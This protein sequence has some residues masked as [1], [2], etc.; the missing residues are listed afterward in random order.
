MPKKASPSV[1]RPKKEYATTAIT[2]HVHT[3][4]LRAARAMA[5][6]EGV[7]TGDLITVA[8][9]RYIKGL[10]IH[11]VVKGKV[12]LLISETIMEIISARN[13]E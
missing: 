6:A 12:T 7:S 3:Q 8:L 5:G 2:V 10:D 4:V 13:R 1:G 11:D 9:W